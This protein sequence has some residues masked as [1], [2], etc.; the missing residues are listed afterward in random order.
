M[1]I[2][3]TI[4]EAKLDQVGHRGDIVSSIRRRP[5]MEITG[6]PMNDHIAAIRIGG[7][8]F[9]PAKEDWQRDQLDKEWKTGEI[10]W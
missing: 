7:R 10:E 1:N 4:K 9:V 6:I 3:I 8:L 5:Q 2:E